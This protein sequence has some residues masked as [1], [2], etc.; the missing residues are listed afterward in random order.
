MV[1]DG[2]IYGLSWFVVAAVLVW[3]TGAWYWAIVPS[4][5]G[6]FLWFFRDPPRSIPAGPG[7]MVSPGDGK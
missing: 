1:R 3:A 2:Y 4:Y 5:F 6:V 7:L